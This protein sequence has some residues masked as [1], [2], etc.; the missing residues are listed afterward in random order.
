MH[1]IIYKE[2][3]SKK[4][5]RLSSSCRKKR[6]KLIDLFRKD[7]AVNQKTLNYLKGASKAVY[8]RYFYEPENLLGASF[9]VKTQDQVKYFCYNKQ[10][11]VKS[12]IKVLFGKNGYLFNT[13]VTD[14][15]RNK[16]FSFLGISSYITKVLS[17]IYIY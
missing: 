17:D 14:Y 13:K 7:F 9:F 4:L 5:Y 2:F 16:K 1:N 15:L 3:I 12:K 10:K 8:G 11:K 6:V